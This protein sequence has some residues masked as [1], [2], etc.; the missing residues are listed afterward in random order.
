MG[1]VMD[2][3]FFSQAED[4]GMD[5]AAAVFGEAENHCCGDETFTIEGQ[6][7][8]KLSFNDLE[9]GQQI[10]LVAFTSAYKD[11]FKVNTEQTVP[12]DSYPPPILVQDLNILYEVF[13]I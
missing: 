2:V 4:C 7:N 10:F 11:L 12:F 9:L 6:D 3:A 8:L 1:R 13:L 5:E